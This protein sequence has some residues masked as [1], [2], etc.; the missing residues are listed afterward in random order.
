MALSP[1]FEQ[2]TFRAIQMRSYDPTRVTVN[3]Q[4]RLRQALVTSATPL[5][6]LSSTSALRRNLL[7][8]IR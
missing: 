4:Q 8:A 3:T 1:W 6:Y 2:G 5:A 7:R